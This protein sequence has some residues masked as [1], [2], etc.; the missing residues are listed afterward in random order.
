MKIIEDEGSDVSTCQ[1]SMRLQTSPSVTCSQ[2][3][4]LLGNAMIHSGMQLAINNQHSTYYLP[5]ATIKSEVHELS[6]EWCCETSQQQLFNWPDQFTRQT[7]VFA[8]DSA[9]PESFQHSPESA[10][11]FQSTPS[12]D[13]SSLDGSTENPSPIAQAYTTSQV[14]FSGFKSKLSHAGFDQPQLKLTELDCKIEGAI[15]AG[16]LVQKLDASAGVSAGQLSTSSVTGGLRFSQ[17]ASADWLGDGGGESTAVGAIS[18]AAAAESDLTSPP[19]SA[20]EELFS[21]LER[22]SVLHHYY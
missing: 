2:P 5:E 1:E 13:S 6:N 21:D 4:A 12:S 9:T 22:Y 15:E 17:Q 11:S 16:D 19:F 10:S 14:S 3:P 18:D 20:M 8:P 7:E